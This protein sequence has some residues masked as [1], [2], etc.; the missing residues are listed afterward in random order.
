M[1]LLFPFCPLKVKE[2]VFECDCRQTTLFAKHTLLGNIF[3]LEVY[4]LYECE[5]VCWPLNGLCSRPDI[6]YRVALI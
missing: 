2:S 5:L 4:H 1:E 3:C 6:S